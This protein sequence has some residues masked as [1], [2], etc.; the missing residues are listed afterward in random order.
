M[1]LRDAGAKMSKSSKSDF[2]RINLLDAPELLHKKITKAKTD[3]IESIYYDEKRPEL[4]NLM[5]IF[6]D[7]TKKNPE[8]LVGEYKWHDITE[9]K[10]QLYE[11]LNQELTPI[12]EKTIELL[13]S[14]SLDKE[15]KEGLDKARSMASQNI[16]QIK[17]LIGFL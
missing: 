12:R 14:D 4:A 13:H 2:T 6:A 17:K 10:N 3:S 9:F 7:L 16:L 15:M 11:R 5:R 1:N 8:E